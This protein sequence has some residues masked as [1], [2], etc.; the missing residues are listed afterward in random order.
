MKFYFFILFSSICFSQS[1]SFQIKDNL[2]NK[3]IEYVSIDL[4][5]G[6]GFYSNE[7]GLVVADFLGE[8]TIELSHVSYE[9]RKINIDEIKDVVFLKQKVNQL[10]EIQ[11][12]QS[13]EKLFITKELEKSKS[14]KACLMGM[15][16]FQIATLI[17]IENEKQCYLN[18]LT[19]PFKINDMLSQ[20]NDDIKNPYSIIEFSFRN[21]INGFPSDTLIENPEFYFIDKKTLKK[22]LIHHSLLNKIKIPNEGVFCTI[23]F[24]GKA[25]ENGNLILE[26][27]T[28]KSYYNG[29]EILFTKYLPLEIPLYIDTGKNK[30]F[31]RGSF[32]EKSVFKKIT[33][34]ISASLELTN[35]ERTEYINNKIEEMDNF[36][37]NIGYKLYYYE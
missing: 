34:P 13:G 25:D 24:L 16:G 19:I 7:V 2:T 30:T 8:K 28:R 20:D 1:I 14:N 31:S 37:I 23:T 26:N 27:P 10:N 35:E 6:K 5:N 29:K 12:I 11:L 18:E 33:P 32:S 9:S 3:G 15:Y 21:N 4:L 17:T 36:K 22:K